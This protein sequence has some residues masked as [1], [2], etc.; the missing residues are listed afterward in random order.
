MFILES[1]LLL[2]LKKDGIEYLR[3]ILLLQL[4]VFLHD[5]H[6]EI[7]LKYGIDRKYYSEDILQILWKVMQTLVILQDSCCVWDSNY[8]AK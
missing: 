1:E 5:A 7:Y 2:A 8:F 4:L 3:K 6:E